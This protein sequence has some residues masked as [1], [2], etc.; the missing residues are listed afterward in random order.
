MTAY[1]FR[2]GSLNLFFPPFVGEED[3]TMNSLMLYRLFL[4]Y[5]R[6]MS[7]DRE[8]ASYKEW[9]SGWSRSN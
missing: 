9:E 1:M 3:L 7:L 6:V 8:A 2:Y 4:E 5:S